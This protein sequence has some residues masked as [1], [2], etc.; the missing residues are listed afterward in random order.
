MNPM[1]IG[2]LG[3]DIFDKKTYKCPFR[4]RACDP[5]LLYDSVST[6]PFLLIVRD[7]QSV[8]VRRS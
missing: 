7:V 2:D 6:D 3:Y 4:E 5:W 8:V 1:S